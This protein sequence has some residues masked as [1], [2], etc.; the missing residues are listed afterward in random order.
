[1]KPRNPDIT[2]EQVRSLLDYSPETGAFKWKVSKAK[3]LRVGDVAGC[4]HKRGYWVIVIDG[5]GYLAHR[6]AWAHT[7]GVWPEDQLDHKNGIRN[8]NRISNLREATNAENH[9]NKGARADNTSGYQGV[10]YKKDRNKWF[11]QIE[12]NGKNK[13]LGYFDSP[14]SAYSA[15]LQAK[16]QLHTFQPVPRISMGVP[17]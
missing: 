4:Q 3:R 15:Y 11:S 10:S 13:H 7:Y 5:R 6:L 16:S 1:M 9:Q 17:Q 2:A 12:A 14:E 8:D